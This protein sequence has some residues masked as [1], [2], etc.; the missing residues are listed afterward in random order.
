[1][2][3]NIFVT[4]FRQQMAWLASNSVLIT[5]E[6][7]GCV[8]S[9]EF[10]STAFEDYIGD[11]GSPAV[12]L[13]GHRTK[14]VKIQAPYGIAVLDAA[15]YVTLRYLKTVIEVNRITGAVTT[16]LEYA[17]NL[18]RLAPFKDESLL[19]GFEHGAGILNLHS[20]SASSLSGSSTSWSEF[21]TNI[22]FNQVE[23]MLAVG[24]SNF[25]LVVDRLNNR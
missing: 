4:F 19:V 15:V 14:N 1:M 16:V 6:K 10:D 17:D 22:G 2:D 8:V 21:G 11:C 5:L 12:I 3:A 9:F 20:F 7:H 13:S 25:I 24:D 23:A 18:L